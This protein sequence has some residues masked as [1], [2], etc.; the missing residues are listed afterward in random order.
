[1]QKWNK[2]FVLKC[3]KTYGQLKIAKNKGT[4]ESEMKK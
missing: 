3:V 4:I 1:M 2:D